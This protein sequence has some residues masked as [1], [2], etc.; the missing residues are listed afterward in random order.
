MLGAFFDDSGTHVGSP[1]IALGGLLGTEDQWDAFATAW[2]ALLASPLDG[3]PP[4]RSFHLTDCRGAHG[5][6]M[7]YNKASRD[8]INCLFRRIIVDLEMVTIAAAVD[9]KAWADL[10]TLSAHEL[11]GDPLGFC[12]VKCMDL[13]LDTIRLR[14]PGEKV[15]VFFD[16]GQKKGLELWASFY[17]MQ[18]QK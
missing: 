16:E 12:F 7:D 10:V 1:V 8:G 14:K 6:F 5:E 11:L 4:L 9:A 3:K 13:M 17:A 18:T 15:L 2:D